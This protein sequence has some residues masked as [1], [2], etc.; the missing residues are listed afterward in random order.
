[1]QNKKKKRIIYPLLAALFGML[2][3]ISIYGWNILNVAYID[4][5]KNAGGDLTQS[6]YGWM[7]FRKS[8]W[9]WPL[10]LMDGAAPDLT[11]I[12]YI[13]SVPLFNVIF[14]LFRNVLPLEC[15]FFGI[16]GL[17]CFVLSGIL[18]YE[19]VYLETEREKTALLASF[20]FIF[21]NIMVQRLYTHTALAA[22]WLIVLGIYV[23]LKEKRNG[24]KHSCLAWAGIFFLCVSINI[25]YIPILG[26]FMA[27]ACLYEILTEKKWKKAFA[28]MVGS[29][30]ATFLT[31][32]LYGGMYHMSTGDASPSGLGYYS[33]N[34]NA[35]FNPMETG[36]Y[37]TGAGR[38]MRTLPTATSG[39][40]EGYAYLGAGLLLLGIFAFAGLLFQGK[41]R[42][43]QYWKKNR[44]FIII[45][46]ISAA[47]LILL[48]MGT[49]VTV[50]TRTLFEIP[51]PSFILKILAIFRSSGRFLWG[52]W[53][54][55]AVIVLVGI[56]KEYEK[57]QAFIIILLCVCV[58]IYDL[59]GMFENR[60]EVYASVQKQ[61]ESTL[62]SSAWE[63]A[64]NGKKSIFMFNH[65][66]YN[67]QYFYDFGELAVANNLGVNDFYY[68]RR[69][70]E[71]IENCKEKEWSD[72]LSGNVDESKLYIFEKA[73]DVQQIQSKM[74]IYQLDDQL[75]GVKKP[76]EEV[77]EIKD[78]REVD[79]N[80]EGIDDT[81]IQVQA[82]LSKGSYWIEVT[83]TDI[84]QVV[85]EVIPG[86]YTGFLRRYDDQSYY[87]GN[88][89]IEEETES[90]VAEV[91]GQIDSVRIFRLEQN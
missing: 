83:G 1:M 57:K 52:V 41:E 28:I 15:Q 31:F 68:S 80:W 55:Y 67:L 56:M 4:W 6:Y 35:L 70:N 19:L 11:S 79:T 89:Q 32:Y 21:N 75:I 3:Y 40:Y 73:E 59:S 46:I 5:I 72:I 20:F 37:L 29:L 74:H 14:K 91:G 10:G 27:M 47:A 54:L 60:H 61:H 23:L 43:V 58:Q 33:A 86:E 16:W 48:S 42:I 8:A 84:S 51:Y 63:D 85:A 36:L 18:G 49:A 82:E 62:K 2:S 64:V 30:A 7:F 44:Y 22:N 65:E 24:L 17:T 13:D 45:L 25:Y 50:N 81:H 34:L 12:I 87:C 9:H 78:I 53:N 69:D 77:T 88:I 39:Q 66:M 38:I 76:I 71:T 26:V 90:F